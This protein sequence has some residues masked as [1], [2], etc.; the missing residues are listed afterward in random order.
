MAH[1]QE[2]PA[3]PPRPEGT[4]QPRGP[5]ELLGGLLE[6]LATSSSDDSRYWYFSGV[7]WQ[8]IVSYSLS[9]DR[10]ARFLGQRYVDGSWDYE[11]NSQVLTLLNIRMR[12]SVQSEQLSRDIL[13]RRN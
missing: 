2:G 5:K 12:A 8:R 3:R 6:C 4:P 10:V 7:R 9:Y 13:N 1:G 11:I